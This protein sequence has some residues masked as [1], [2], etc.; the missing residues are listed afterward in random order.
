MVVK[1]KTM[2]TCQV[3]RQILIKQLVARIDIVRDL[4]LRRMALYNFLASFNSLLSLD[5]LL[6]IDFLNRLTGSSAQ[7]CSKLY[8]SSVAVY[9]SCWLPDTSDVTLVLLPVLKDPSGMYF[10][11]QHQAAEKQFN[12]KT[13]EKTSALLRSRRGCFSFNLVFHPPPSCL[14][15][16]PY[17]VSW[18]KWLLKL[19]DVTITS[20]CS[21]VDGNVNRCSVLFAVFKV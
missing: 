14:R 5:V 4:R 12:E 9:Y 11:R 19:L 18:R 13:R 1:Y 6:G 16:G 15:S 8:S 10:Q 7:N 17:I 3:P 2:Q 20:F 21:R